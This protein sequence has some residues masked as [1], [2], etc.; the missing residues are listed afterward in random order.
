MFGGDEFNAHL[1]LRYGYTLDL[2]ERFSPLVYKGVELPLTMLR[3]Y[4]V[5]IQQIVDEKREDWAF[6]AQKQQR[7][8]LNSM[9]DVQQRLQ[10]LP[11]AQ[12]QWGE[13]PGRNIILMC[14]QFVDLALSQ[15]PDR[16]VLLLHSNPYDLKALEHKVL[17]P[18]FR[19]FS[20]HERVVAGVVSPEVKQ[21]Y[22]S[23]SD[24]LTS[25]ENKEI[26]QHEIFSLPRFPE[27]MR[28]QVGQGLVLV[29]ILDDILRQYP[30]KVILDH[31]ELIYPGNILSI[32]ARKYGLPFIN[33]QNHLTS[34]ASIIPSRATHY[35]V[36]GKNMAD[37]LGRRGIPRE[38][39]FEVGSLRLENNEIMIG[40][41]RKQLLKH[42]KI[43]DNPLIITYTTE[44]YS[45]KINFRMVRWLKKAAKRLPVLVV[46][47]PHPSDRLSYE[48]YLSENI[49]MVPPDFHLQDILHASD[50]VA[51]ISSTT[52]IEAAMLKKGIIVL[53]P[54]LPYD[55]HI[56]YNG[57]PYFLAK[58]NAGVV[59]HSSDELYNQ[60]K[61]LASD[62][63][64]SRQVILAGQEFL[65]HTLHPG[66]EK[67][68]ERIARLVAACC[69]I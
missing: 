52:A 48:S 28:S 54:D 21:H 60:L 19:V 9:H 25:P 40:K 13:D 31:S 15:F 47:K 6:V 44:C 2:F 18:G 5:Y 11:A 17:P 8:G 1:L 67:P 69:V 49:R 4:H 68:S 57:Y 63:N 16:Q 59:V 7:W 12:E 61:Q 34:D 35:A 38:S 3:P 50:Y 55:Y 58:G 27:W 39:M 53:Q 43:K 56:N 41:T 22:F 23:L 32:L 29:D 51:T 46:I 64:Y 14:G 62:V 26:A 33:V 42:Y 66:A 65:Q 30:V 20:V 10:R 37:W 24:Q 36:W 45:E